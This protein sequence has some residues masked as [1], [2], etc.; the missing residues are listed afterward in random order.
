MFALFQ[1]K[2]THLIVLEVS[3]FREFI[4][5]KVTGVF[6]NVFLWGGEGGHNW[7]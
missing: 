2:L 5:L 1:T 3:K 4:A 7:P 6:R